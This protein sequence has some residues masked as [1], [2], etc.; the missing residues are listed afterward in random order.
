M[1]RSPMPIG[2]SYLVTTDH[3]TDTLTIATRTGARS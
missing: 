3:L 2:L 1:P